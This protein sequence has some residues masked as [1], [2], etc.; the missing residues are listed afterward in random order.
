MIP[1]PRLL[2]QAERTYF[3]FVR[4]Q[5]L[6]QWWH[7]IAL[8]ATLMLFL[9]YIVWMYR[10]DS[11]ELPIATRFLLIMLRICAFAG[12][13]FFFLQFEKRS[14]QRIIKNSRLVMLV[15]TSQSMG[16]RDSSATPTAETPRRI[17]EIIQQLDQ[18]DLLDD[19]QSQHDLTVYRFDQDDTPS[20]ITTRLKPISDDADD[21]DDLAK[22][23]ARLSEASNIYQIAGLFLAVALLAFVAHW[24]LGSA[25]R[26]REGES[27]AGP[28]EWLRPI[29]D[30]AK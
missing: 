17:D 11:R 19:L 5:S 9:A 22:R 3:E 28:R 10:R 7:W 23:K 2:A 13:L 12:L 4:L 24:I 8:L 6:N 1:L 27:W 26:S 21:G 16:L 25:V 30:A 18:T 14:E 15:D 20:Q 29:E